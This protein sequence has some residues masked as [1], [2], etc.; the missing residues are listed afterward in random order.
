MVVETKEQMKK[1][2]FL[3]VLVIMAGIAMTQVHVPQIAVKLANVPQQDVRGTSGT[4]AHLDLLGQIII[5]LGGAFGVVVLV[6]G[7]R[8]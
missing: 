8:K 7:V 4:C 2:W 3:P 6:K 5:L 1:F